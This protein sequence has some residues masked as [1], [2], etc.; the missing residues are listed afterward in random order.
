[1]FTVGDT[2]I[3]TPYVYHATSKKV[4][5]ALGGSE[6]ATL[7]GGDASPLNIKIKAYHLV[8]LTYKEN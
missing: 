4:I 5:L 1:M 7:L 2:V 8:H 3:A 6:D